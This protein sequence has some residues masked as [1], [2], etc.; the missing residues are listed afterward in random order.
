M[1]QLLKGLK[2][3]RKTPH[4]SPKTR[5]QIRMINRDGRMSI[6]RIGISRS[7]WQ[8]VYH[9]LSTLSWVNFLGLVSL[10]YLATNTLFALL[11]LADR[12]GI[13][14]AK[15]GD[16][17]DAFFFS[18]QTIGTLG[19]GSMYPRTFYTNWVVTLETFIGILW[20]AVVTGLM[21]ARFS[22]PTARVLFSQTATIAPYNGVLTLMFRA[23]NER[24]NQIVEAQLTLTLI[25]DEVTSEGEVVR[26]F[27]DLKLV[28]TRSP[29]FALTWTVMHQIDETSLLFGQTPESLTASATEIIVTLTGLDATLSQTIH[30]RHSYIASEML[31]NMRFVD[32]IVH[33]PDGKRAVDYTHFHK[34]MP[35]SETTESMT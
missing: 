25:R 33:L 8:D 11:Y 20:I 17:W 22:R 26:R 2:S 10:L 23:A 30:A 34:V 9:R 31:W 12:Y 3:I 27:H 21:F 6:R 19:Y 24:D 29:I 5:P 16:F 4:S 14:N 32:I 35:L 28:R 15:P 1:I 13:V 7:P 18:V